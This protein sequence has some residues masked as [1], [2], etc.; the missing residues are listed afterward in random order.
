[1]S[2]NPQHVNP[3]H[4]EGRTHIEWC[5]QKALNTLKGGR[6]FALANAYAQLNADLMRNP[7]TKHIKL[8]NEV[9]SIG[10]FQTWI[11]ENLK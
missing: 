5:R 8:P 6:D 11:E 1:M 7:T 9:R 3:R 4:V 2:D 10:E